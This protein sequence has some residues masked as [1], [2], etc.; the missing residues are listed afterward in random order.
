MNR[1]VNESLFQVLVV[2]LV[3]L[4]LAV[5]LTVVPS[6]IEIPSQLG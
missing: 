5:L 4:P 3:M 1:C 6:L 2:L